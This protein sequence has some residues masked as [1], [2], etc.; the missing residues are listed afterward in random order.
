MRLGRLVVIES[1]LNLNKAHQSIWCI[2]SR[3]TQKKIKKMY[4][5]FSTQLT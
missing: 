3:Y 2:T 4:Q 1:Q 5:K